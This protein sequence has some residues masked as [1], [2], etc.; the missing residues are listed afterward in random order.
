MKRDDSHHLSSPDSFTEPP[1]GSPR[2]LCL[3]PAC[4]TPHICHKVGEK[5]RVEGLSERVDA[6]LV[7]DIP[8]TGFF[9]GRT[10]IGTLEDDG[11]FYPAFHR[12]CPWGDWL[13][14]RSVLPLFLTQVV[15]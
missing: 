1:L 8:T 3:C 6:E 10:K 15:S 2:E 14:K 11:F 13:S 9:G 4:D 12:E 5:S 7:E